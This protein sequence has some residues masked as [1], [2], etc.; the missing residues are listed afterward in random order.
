M[1]WTWQLEFKTWTRLF[2]FHIALIQLGMVCIQLF[3]LQLLNCGMATGLGEAKHRI[4]TCLA[5]FEIELMLHLACVEGFINKYIH[6]HTHTHTHTY[7]YIYIYKYRATNFYKK[8][9]F[10]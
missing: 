4:R 6:T 1:K 10:F 7:I 5:T 2:E 3:S 8:L 9:I